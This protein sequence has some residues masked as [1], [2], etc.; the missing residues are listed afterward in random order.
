MFFAD[1]FQFLIHKG[2]SLL[3]PTTLFSIFSFRLLPVIPSTPSVF[4]SSVLAFFGCIRTTLFSYLLHNLLIFSLMLISPLVISILLIA[5]RNCSLIFSSD[6]LL[7]EYVAHLISLS[8]S[9]GKS[10][11][12]FTSIIKYEHYL[13]QLRSNSTSI[14]IWY[15]WFTVFF[16]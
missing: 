8:F 1:C 7:I 2:H 5:P 3:F 10:V 6:S 16:I 12:H 13:Y 9:S 11:L 14:I 15:F 4:L